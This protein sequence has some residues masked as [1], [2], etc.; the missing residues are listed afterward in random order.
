MKA[1]VSLYKI[2]QTRCASCNCK[3]ISH[4][5]MYPIDGQTGELKGT[6]G[7][8]LNCNSRMCTGYVPKNPSK[9]KPV[10]SA[11]SDRAFG[12]FRE[13]ILDNRIRYA[14]EQE[15]DKAL[16]DSK[17]MVE[18]FVIAID[19]KLQDSNLSQTEVEKYAFLDHLYYNLGG[20][21]AA[22]A[23]SYGRGYGSKRKQLKN[24][25]P[26]WLAKIKDDGEVIDHFSKITI[27]RHKFKPEKKIE[28]PEI[29]YSC[30]PYNVGG[31]AL[32]EY[33]L[34]LH[35]AGIRTRISGESEY[36][37]GHTFELRFYP[38]TGTTGTTTA[39]DN[40]DH[41]ERGE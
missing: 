33:I 34:R 38:P 11:L 27:H 41:D 13:D 32:A 17:K 23:E 29:K 20:V 39:D 25:K 8:C 2:K 16:I 35:K 19:S 12:L 7:K 31:L 18:D 28:E 26:K 21:M 1:K 9:I 30:H 14:D 22:L 37:P 24:K 4:P 6:N 5:G 40:D 36:F 10:R 15:K 3:M